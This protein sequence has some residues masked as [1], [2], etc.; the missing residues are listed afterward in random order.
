[1]AN[2]ELL[3]KGRLGAVV[4]ID[5]FVERKKMY[6]VS[7]KRSRSEVI[8]TRRSAVLILPLL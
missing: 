4:K 6:F 8:S 2:R 7:F 1:M 5:C 3:L